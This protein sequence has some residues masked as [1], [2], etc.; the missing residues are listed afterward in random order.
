MKIQ[1]MLKSSINRYKVEINLLGFI[2]ERHLTNKEKRFVDLRAHYG[3]QNAINYLHQRQLDA[4]MR[5]LGI[6][7]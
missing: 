5:E 4:L 7:L 2:D 3:T 1:G 6:E